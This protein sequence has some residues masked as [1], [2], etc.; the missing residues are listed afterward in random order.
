MPDFCAD[1]TPAEYVSDFLH[2]QAIFQ[3]DL[4]EGWLPAPVNQAEIDGVTYTQRTYVLP[5]QPREGPFQADCAVAS[6]C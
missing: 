2:Q 5:R 3:R 6:D 1:G 4:A